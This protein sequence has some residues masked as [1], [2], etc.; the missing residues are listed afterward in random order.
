MADQPH[1][2]PFTFTLSYAL[3]GIV[4]LSLVANMAFASGCVSASRSGREACTVSSAVA[5]VAGAIPAVRRAVVSIEDQGDPQRA[6]VVGNILAFVWATTIAT[7]L[8][9]AAATAL[10]VALLGRDEKAD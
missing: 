10:R 9:M 5:T 7:A 3:A 6:A 2:R 8:A 1:P 4:L